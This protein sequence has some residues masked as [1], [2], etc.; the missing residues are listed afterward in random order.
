MSPMV[1]FICPDGQK[2]TKEDCF[3][4]C[5]TGERC[6]TLEY[7][8]LAIKDLPQQHTFTTTQLL[9]PFRKSFLKITMPFYIHPN[10]MTHTVRGHKIHQKYTKGHDFAINDGND[11]GKHDNLAPDNKKKGYFIL[12]EIKTKKGTGIFSF[13][14]FLPSKEQEQFKYVTLQLN[15]YRIKLEKSGT[16]ISRLQIELRFDGNDEVRVIPVP[17]LPDDYVKAYFKDRASKLRNYITNNEVPPIC[18]FEETWGGRRCFHC[19][20][21]SLCKEIDNG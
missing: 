16:L 2:V 6:Q 20:V 9:N 12:S 13:D 15:N 18:S 19:E 7:L 17:K 8:H 1:G 21:S 10:A 4:Q 11:I 5:R 14:H 3:K